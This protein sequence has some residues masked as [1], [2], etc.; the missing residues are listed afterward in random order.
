MFHPGDRVFAKMKGFPFWP[1]RVDPLPPHVELPKGKVPVFFYGTHQV[2]FLSPKNLVSFEDH[3][4]AYGKRKVLIKAMIEIES[5]PE[6][7]LLGKDPAAEAFWESLY[8]REC[9]E[10]EREIDNTRGRLSRSNS[11]VT[12][13]ASK[14]KASRPPRAHLTKRRKSSDQDDD[15]NS[16]SPI[17]DSVD[18]VLLRTMEPMS[19]QEETCLE[20]EE[21]YLR[22]SEVDKWTSRKRHHSEVESN[23]LVESLK[24]V[25]EAELDFHFDAEK[26]VSQAVKDRTMVADF[27]TIDSTPSKEVVEESHAEIL[28]NDGSKILVENI[29]NDRVEESY[30][31]HVSLKAG[32]ETTDELVSSSSSEVSSVKKD[33]PSEAGEIVR[34]PVTPEHRQSQRIIRGG[35]L[36]R[37]VVDLDA[38]PEEEESR[39][40][41]SDD[42]GSDDDDLNDDDPNDYD[43]CYGYIRKQKKTD[44]RSA[45]NIEK[46]K[47]REI[48]NLC[49]GKNN[50][51]VDKSEA[52]GEFRMRTSSSSEREFLSKGSRGGE[53]EEFHDP[54]LNDSDILQNH[55][56]GSDEKHAIANHGSM[57]DDAIDL[58]NHSIERRSQISVE[59][60]IFSKKWKSADENEGVQ[61]SK[62]LDLWRKSDAEGGCI[63][64]VPVGRDEARMKASN[65]EEA[66]ERVRESSDDL[67]IEEHC[68]V[69]QVFSC[70]L[71]AINVETLQI[72]HDLTVQLKSNLV[73]GHEK[74]G[75]A[76]GVLERI[77]AT[78]VSLLQLTKVWELTD[79]VKKCRK[80]RLSAEV[81]DAASRAL[82]YFQKIQA[83]ASK[84][85]VL[86]AKGIVAERLRR[87]KSEKP[88]LPPRPLTTA[89]P[90]ASNTESPPANLSPEQAQEK[91]KFSLEALRAELDAKADLLLARLAATEARL[92]AERN[93]TTSPPVAP[94]SSSTTASS[95]SASRRRTEETAKDV[96]SRVDE[97]ASRLG[98]DSGAVPPPPPPPPPPPRFVRSQQVDLDTRIS[99]LMMGV[100]T[101][102]SRPPPHPQIQ[103]PPSPPL[104]TAPA[105]LLALREQIQRKRRSA[106]TAA[107]NTTEPRREKVEKTADDDIYDLLG[108]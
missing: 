78:K 97:V 51:F 5:D 28:P 52:V 33:V 27:R 15:L 92:M 20:K 82:S 45:H 29:I 100:I 35:K 67:F 22:A 74:F 40:S 66:G 17:S 7:L 8:P 26:S 34:N 103:S 96:L 60:E 4:D 81:R 59:A 23:D 39:C 83:A 19:E 11:P 48:R 71:V 65:D 91:K 6:V 69:W 106:A 24:R 88:P 21:E 85:E 94:S 55:I 12:K 76:V 77:C 108:V 107:A 68:T 25:K 14:R 70:Y 63:S 43:Y 58:L 32:V 90:S 89:A 56:A 95:V 3:K 31:G 30:N 93:K 72:L 41:R 1:A 64:E 75:A 87:E 36:N 13:K 61:R 102:P 42:E 50:E 99:Q 10:M 47:G 54:K 53:C 9:G 49:R 37:F 79:C 16:M 73:R 44:K 101:P 46:A 84:E 104:L 38:E 18:A 57:D 80:Y 86:K 62:S 105:K 98:V 2:S